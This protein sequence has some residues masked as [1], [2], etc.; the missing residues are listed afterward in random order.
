MRSTIL[1][2]GTALVLTASPA[3]AGGSARTSGTGLLRGL[4]A[5]GTHNSLQR[6]GNS[7]GECLC[8]TAGAVLKGARGAAL[9][10]MPGKA[11]GAIA[12]MPRT[13]TGARMLVNSVV[14]LSGVRGAKGGN[15]GGAGTAIGLAGTLD[16]NASFGHAHGSAGLGVGLAGIVTVNSNGLGIA[17]GHGRPLASASVMN[18][19]S[20]K[21]GRVANVSVL[22]HRGSSGHSAVSA[23]AFNGGGGSSGRIANVSALNRAGTQGHSAVNVAALNGSGGSSGKFVDVSV[24]NRAASSGHSV[25]QV[26]ALNGFAHGSGQKGG[27][28]NGILVGGFRMI[29]GVLCL[30]DGTPLSGSAAKA[31]M[32]A[33]QPSGHGHGS[34]STMGSG[35]RPQHASNNSIRS[36]S[37][38]PSAQS[39]NAPPR[40]SA[41]GARGGPSD[42]DRRWA[43]NKD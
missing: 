41:T 31:V 29:N 18:A 36:P 27:G 1:I 33:I 28:G 39:S 34:E 40:M 35:S 14:G 30:P 19:G 22:N 7:L 20:H 25:V 5:G 8:D 16:G 2:A 3:L 15:H 10:G 12:K 17:S 38:S 23:A 32:A 24:L 21:G 11:N 37:T 13:G 42:Y 6:S 9:V 4:L 43:P 26:A